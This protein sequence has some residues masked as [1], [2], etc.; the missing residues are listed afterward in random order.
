MRVL[1]VSLYWPPAGGAGV[2]R[3]L[4]L[5]EHLSALGHDVHVLAPDDP[6]WLHRDPSLVI[7]SGV[8]V[9]RSRN[10]GP[11]ARRPGQE[12]ARAQGLDRLLLQLELG[13]RAVLVP[14]AS[15]LW[16]LT[17]APAA[18]RLVRRHRVDAVITTSPPGS[19]HLT[20]AAAK[21]ATGVPWVAD[22]R[23]SLVQHVHRRR[24]IRGE[25]V[26]ARLVA[27]HADAIVCVSK[28][29]AGE[30]RSL[31]PVGPVRVV[32]NG[33]DFGDFDGLPYRPAARLRVTHAGSFFGR[34]DPRP[35][36]EALARTSDDVVARFV[37]DFRDRDLE[38]ARRLGLEQR[39]QLVPYLPRADVL[40][41]QRDSEVLLLLIPEAE[42]RGRGVLSGKVF[43]YLAAERPILACVP[44]DGEAA[45][46]LRET[47]AGV[48]VPPDDAEAIA[49][50]LDGLVA[51]WRAGELNGTPLT[52]EWRAALSRRARAEDY[53]ALLE[54][55][56][57]G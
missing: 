20:G 27:R 36:L 55:V 25:H 24:E 9:H 46:L 14:D 34:R 2:Q 18:I 54:K 12:L 56:T 17:A 29:I 48:I 6:K 50:A 52:S 37:G 1:I 43:E 7:P 28:A 3:P 10:V 4:K 22:V 33:C 47:G 21:R 8:T 16:N 11:R 15:V 49:A 32:G 23:D 44:P 42:G 31:A 41:L 19:V 45:G 30:M 57:T 13:F 38:H 26:L 35:F 39:L 5:A 51:R 53:A 40:A